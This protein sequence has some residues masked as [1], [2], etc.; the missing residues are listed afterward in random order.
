MIDGAAIWW[1][2]HHRHTQLRTGGRK[3]ILGLA[4]FS[5]L[6]IFYGSYIEPQ[7]ILVNEEAIILSDQPTHTLRVALISDIHVGPYKQKTFVERIVKKTNAQHPD[8]ILLDGDFISSDASEA[9]YLEPLKKLQAPHGVFAVLGNHDYGVEMDGTLSNAKMANAVKNKLFSLGIRVLQNQGAVIAKDGSSLYLLGTDEILTGKASISRSLTALHQK[10][11]APYPTVLLSHNA[12][13]IIGAQKYG[14]HLVLA[15]HTHGGQVRLPFIGA[16]PPLP[17]R[18]GNKYDRGLFRFGN[19]Q[20][21]ITSGI[22]E[23]GARAR[24]LVPPEVSMLE[25]KY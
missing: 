19:T 25:I 18:I 15:A 6:V 13:A 11:P 16:V 9:A 22:G 1:L 8:V 4:V 24:L 2:L 10:N 14:I 3:A 21:F 20:L 17:H 12:D 7:I 23:S 5:W